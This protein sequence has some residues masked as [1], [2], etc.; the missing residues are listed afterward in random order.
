VVQAGIDEQS[1][2]Q[3]LAERDERVG[4]IEVHA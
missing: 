1:A 3:E 2:D 4:E